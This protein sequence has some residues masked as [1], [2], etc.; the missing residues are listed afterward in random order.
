MTLRAEWWIGR[1]ALDAPRT[2]PAPHPLF[3]HS[4]RDL[5]LVLS[6][7]GQSCATVAAF[8]FAGRAL[9]ALAFGVG[10]L[11]CSNTISHNQLHTP[12][13]RAR[14]LNRALTLWITL[15][16]GVPQTLWR[17]RHLWHHAG[18]PKRKQRA[19]PAR[20]KTEIMLVAALWLL[21]FAL[22]PRT[23]L[24]AYLPGYALGMLL[25]RLQGD[26]EH[27]LETDRHR[28]VSYY[29]AL[30][31]F[32]WFNDGYHAEHH[33]WPA[34]HWTRLPDRR[35]Q[36]IAPESAYPPVLRPLEELPARVN[37]ASAA[38][39]SWLEGVALGSR[40]IQ[41]FMLWTHRRAIRP[42]LSQLQ[43]NPLDVVIVGGGLFPRSLLI[44]A[45]LLPR[46]RF[47]VVDRSL[48]NVSRAVD[49]LKRRGFPLSRVRFVIESFDP[50][51]HGRAHLVVA[52]LAFVGQQTLLERVPSPL[53]VHDWI[54][55]SRHATATRVVSLFLLKRVSLRFP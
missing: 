39:L 1:E 53:L 52:P 3:R 30:Y 14:W 34:E 15:L 29:G 6:L 17:A 11:W 50:A 4:A 42:L 2:A 54:W 36:M 38:L 25:C 49:Q 47:T 45:E 22:D 40:A 28:G 16:T 32:F 5:W 20:A 31:N 19:L 51:A 46:A 43:T 24:L 26:M 35:G 37:E 10:I 33:R 9:G 8:A 7:L 18:E 27:A 21:G 44:L 41:S 48:E 23:F 13:F 55:R 12:L